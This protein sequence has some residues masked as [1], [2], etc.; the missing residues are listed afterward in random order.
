MGCSVR[1]SSGWLVSERLNRNNQRDS[2][3]D[4]DIYFHGEGFRLER[5]NIAELHDLC[6][7]D[8]ITA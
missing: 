8:N 7:Y 1:E 2:I 4:R 6:V 3:G 5:L